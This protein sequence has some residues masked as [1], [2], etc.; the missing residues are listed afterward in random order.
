MV[1]CGPELEPYFCSRFLVSGDTIGA[2]D[3]LEKVNRIEGE[4]L[5]I[6]PG[7]YNSHTHLGDSC[8]L[9]GTTG[10]TLEEGFFRPNGFKY[11]E[12]ALLSAEEQIPFIVSQMQYMVRTGTVGHIDFREEG[13]KGVE[14][15]KE[16]SH[17]VGLD[18]VI[19]SQWMTSPFDAAALAENTA[20]LN[21]DYREELE[22][23]LAGSD[24]FSESTM[25]DM[26]SPAWR[27]IRDRTRELGKLRAIH[28]LENEG[29]R[30]DS[31]AVEGRGDL[32][33]AIDLL[34]PHLIIHMTVATPQEQDQLAASGITGVMNPRANANL[35]L[36]LPPL[37]GL[38]DAGA[39]LLLGTDNAMLNN[40]SMLAELDFTYKLAKSQYGDAV[41]PQPQTILK[42]ATSNIEKALG[43]DRH[44][45]LEKGLPADFVV[46]DFSQSRLAHT[47]HL[48]AS[49][50]TRLGAG[51]VLATVHRG[52]PLYWAEQFDGGT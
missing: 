47:R 21:D 32:A 46:L 39:N 13:V 9:D 25:N 28:C 19:L 30:N 7:L 2:I 24:G 23:I 29:Y 10:L 35:G 16:A 40:C 36:P 18:S 1:L 15:L 14:I 31:L 26:T 33:R 3:R 44:G 27:Y 5:V 43:G 48:L 8:L 34:E 11:R 45:Y 38:L 37:R 22:A 51:D 17:R 50:T 12:L 20:S 6:I 42:M 49:I 4:G 52:K 41:L